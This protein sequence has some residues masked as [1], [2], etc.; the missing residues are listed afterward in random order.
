V[1]HSFKISSTPATHTH[2]FARLYQEPSTAR[3]P[4][5]HAAHFVIILNR[6]SISDATT[7]ANTQAASSR[8]WPRARS[9]SFLRQEPQQAPEADCDKW[10][11]RFSNGEASQREAPDT[12]HQPRHTP[13]TREEEQL[14]RQLA[15]NQLQKF[16]QE[17][18]FGNI[19]AAEQIIKGIQKGKTDGPVEAP[20]VKCETK[21]QGQA[22][23]ECT[24]L[25]R[26]YRKRR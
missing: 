13:P 17:E 3:R 24:I 11:G 6:K 23:W 25:R 9:K 22:E 2:S 14:E 20:S 26:L 5:P 16:H 4:A 18:L 15:A 10:R 7:K 12:L 1:T 19:V 8:S 21:G